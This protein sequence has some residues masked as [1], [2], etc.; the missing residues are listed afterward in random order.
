MR[1][2]H[3]GQEI[4]LH[5]STLVSK[6]STRTNLFLNKKEE[7]EMDK[8]VET[9]PVDGGLKLI[10]LDREKAQEI[11]NTPLDTNQKIN[12][13][14]AYQFAQGWRD[15]TGTDGA[16]SFTGFCCVDQ[17]EE[18]AGNPDD[19]RIVGNVYYDRDHLTRDLVQELLTKGE[20]TLYKLDR[21]PKPPTLILE[22]DGLTNSEGELY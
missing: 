17:W 21:S 7:N 9:V 8:I 20:V 6:Y 14:L 2:A 10:V 3:T 4:S 16:G 19:I 22:Y 1:L 5:C 18:V 12:Q 13:V 11:A 15:L